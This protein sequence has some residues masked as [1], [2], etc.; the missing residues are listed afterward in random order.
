MNRTSI[1]TT[2]MLAALAASGS[3]LAQSSGEQGTGSA[4]VRVHAEP[5]GAAG[6]V[7]FSGTPAGVVGAGGSLE[8]SGLEPG[9]YAATASGGFAGYALRNISCDDGASAAPSTGEGATATLA[10]EPGETV[11]CIFH[12][13]R[14]SN[15]GKTPATAPQAPGGQP[16]EDAPGGP[17]GGGEEDPGVAGGEACEPTD[18]VPRAGTWQVSNLPGRMVCGAMIN[19]PLTPS[20]EP[21]TLVVED[22]GWTVIGTGM[23]EGTAPLTMRAVDRSSG[24]YTGTVGGAQDG[25]PMT[26]EFSWQLKSEEWIVGDLRSQVTRQGMTCTMTRPF[27][28]RYSGG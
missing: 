25:V 16:G 23:A 6:S 8:A 11:T 28:L 22:C 10:I 5:P 19:M 20:Q 18:T 1:L 13:A 21:G 27:E 24:R 26:I 12:Y 4:I 3:A 15:A 14:D 9:S 2:S 7:T 17:G